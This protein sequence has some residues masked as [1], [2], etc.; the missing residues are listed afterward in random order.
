MIAKAVQVP[1]YKEDSSSESR[2]RENIYHHLTLEHSPKG[3]KGILVS[4]VTVRRSLSRNGSPSV[5]SE[6]I[7]SENGSPKS[8]RSSKIKTSPTGSEG[9]DKY[10]AL[11]KDYLN[12]TDA[13][14]MYQGIKPTLFS[15]Y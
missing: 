8:N 5:N 14:W 4:G 2:S 13:P 6:V 11:E 1:S 12:L 7:N 10:Y 3:V 15:R 9:T